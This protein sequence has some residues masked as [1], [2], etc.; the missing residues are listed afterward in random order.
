MVGVALGVVVPDDDVGMLGTE[1]ALGRL[2]LGET[3]VDEPLDNNE[4]ETVV[5]GVCGLSKSPEKGT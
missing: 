3:G 5:W 1:L 2:Q 4:G